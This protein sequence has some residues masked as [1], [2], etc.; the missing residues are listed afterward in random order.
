MMVSDLRSYDLLVSPLCIDIR[1]AGHNVPEGKKDLLNATPI[2][3]SIVL[4]LRTSLRSVLC[5]LL[6]P[7]W[8]VSR[9]FH[10]RYKSQRFV[11]SSVLAQDMIYTKRRLRKLFTRDELGSGACIEHTSSYVCT[12]QFLFITCIY[13]Y[14]CVFI[15]Q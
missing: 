11:Y 2:I 15:H 3:G 13:I 7:C 12:L 6:E 1:R 10:Y 5:Q 4:L 8:I 14:H 9:I